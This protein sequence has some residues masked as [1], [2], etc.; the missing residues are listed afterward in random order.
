MRCGLSLAWLCAGTA[1]LAGPAEA[2]TPDLSDLNS[3]PLAMVHAPLAK[4]I[5]AAAGKSRPF[6]FA[7]KAPLPVS[8]ADGSWDRIDADTA[9]W[10]MRVA[11]PGAQSLGFE[12]SHF[13]LPQGGALWI[14]DAAGQLIQGPYTAADE[15]PEGKL[16]TAVVL[17]DQAVLELRVASSLREAVQLELDNVAHG[18]RG[19]DQAEAVPPKSGSCN[20][21][22]VCPQ[23]DAW[24][25]EIRSVA[26]ITIDNTFR[27]S[28]QLLNNTRQ[29]NDP[30]FITANHCEIGQNACG[31]AGT[32]ECSPSSVVFYWNYFN[33]SCRSAT[34]T[35]DR[36]G[37]GSLSQS[38]SGAS[39]LAGDVTSDFTLLRL[40]QA[41]PSA[42]NVYLAGWNA[43]NNVPHS[44]IAI[45][46]PS[47]DEKSLA[48]F[49]SDAERATTQIDNNRNVD[50]WGVHW[51]QGT[52]EQGSSGG[53]LWDENHLIV[54][55]LS[56]GEATCSTPSGED[57]FG[58]ME[59]AWLGNSAP[60]GQLKA[61]LAPDGGDALSLCGK[62]QSGGKC[63]NSNAP[64]EQ[65]GGGLEWI[66][67]LLLGLMAALRR[68]S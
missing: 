7:V 35:A 14:Y 13:H 64:T 59:V 55:W 10:R 1:L 50:S 42:Y 30:L 9:R 48:I 33:S 6:Q 28:G 40:A 34:G 36:N 24:R 18:F 67:L 58:R 52:T 63:D 61:W 43:G 46:H 12:F 3:L 66:S 47:G 20:V 31:P 26:R 2:L 29:N 16:W 57:F 60:S 32:S 44:G 37:N 8:L 38:Q 5:E 4:R 56:G 17:G 22:A 45:H 39:L 62:N 54:G 15:T 25:G 68:Q 27:C 11:S 19:F 23:G 49:S 41:P 51:S 21:D 53:G 65:R